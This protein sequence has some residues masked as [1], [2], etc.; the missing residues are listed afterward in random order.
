[1]SEILNLILYA[2]LSIQLLAL[3]VQ[4]RQLKL[5][6]LKTLMVL[7]IIGIP[8]MWLINTGAGQVNQRLISMWW[9]L[10]RL[11]ASLNILVVCYTAVLAS[12]HNYLNPQLLGG[13]DVPDPL[14]H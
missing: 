13:E 6:I 10:V 3:L 11:P 8:G 2:V 7:T 4:I 12:A 9:R 1:M 14:Q 5:P